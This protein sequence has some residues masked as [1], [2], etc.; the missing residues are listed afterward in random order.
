MGV[1]VGDKS[2]LLPALRISVIFL[3]VCVSHDI[4]V[5]DTSLRTFFEKIET[6][7]FAYD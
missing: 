2:F 5:T 4:Q 6:L 3:T 7:D 1:F